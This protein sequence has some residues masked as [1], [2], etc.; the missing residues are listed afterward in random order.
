MTDLM[1][2]MENFSYLLFVLAENDRKSTNILL[3]YEIY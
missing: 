1:N 3:N 2:D